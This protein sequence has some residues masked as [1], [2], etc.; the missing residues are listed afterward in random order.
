MECRPYHDKEALADLLSP[1]EGP[2]H[3]LEQSSSHQTYRA[4]IALRRWTK[5]APRG[6]PAWQSSVMPQ[7]SGRRI[8][9][10][11]T[12]H[13]P[14]CLQ[15]VLVFQEIPVFHPHHAVFIRYGDYECVHHGRSAHD[16]LCT[17]TMA[18]TEQQGKKAP[19]K[20]HYC[21]RWIKL[22]CHQQQLAPSASTLA[23]HEANHNARSSAAHQCKVVG[24]VD[25]SSSIFSCVERL[26][27]Q[28]NFV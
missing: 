12:Q 22:V 9:C 21:K 24:Q 23:P 17:S 19:C 25:H 13:S 14:A 28:D 20:V 8:L 2:M 4:L 11:P 16:N 5:A 15:S 27:Y 18:H 6:L 1:S 26:T 3:I 7:M 10:P